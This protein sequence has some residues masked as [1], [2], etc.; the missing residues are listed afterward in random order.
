MDL[1]EQPAGVSWHAAVPGALIVL[2]TLVSGTHGLLAPRETSVPQI[3]VDAVARL[4]RAR[5]ALILDVRPRDAYAGG[6]LPGAVSM[7]LGEI[8][9]RAFEFAA[10]RS[11]PVVVYCRNGARSGPKAT[12]ELRR[13]GY[14]KA[15]NMA[16]GLEAW[17]RAGLT[18]ER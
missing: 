12:A 4:V 3:A 11:K 15:A 5:D 17:S 10:Y 6:H 2:A 7:P 18:L 8:S 9:R 14:R 1:Q 13:A 16:G